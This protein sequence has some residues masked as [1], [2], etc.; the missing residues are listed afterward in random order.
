MNE[1]K[2]ELGYLTLQEMPDGIVIL[3]DVLTPVFANLA[4]R[5]FLQISEEG[6]PPRLPHPE[7][8]SMARRALFEGSDFGST[9]HFDDQERDVAVRVIPLG[10]SDGVAITVRD[11]THEV[12]TQQVRK[13]FVV[14][15]SHELKTPVTG[16]LALGEAI[17]EALP[18]D[19]TAAERLSEQLIRDADRLGKLTQD[20]LDLSRIEDPSSI[21]P[22][23]VDLAELARHEATQLKDLAEGRG[24]EVDLDLEE[25]TVVS[26]DEQQLGLM[27]RNLIDNA[28]RYTEEGGRVRIE[29]RREREAVLAVADNGVGIPLRDQARVFERF[30]RVD[31]GRGRERGGSGLGLSI[32][33]HVAELH[34][35]HV[36]LESELGEGSTFSVR[37][38]LA[39]GFR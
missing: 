16:L 18:A 21:R 29:T 25:R 33:R 22:T 12:R 5:Q 7:L 19:V 11:V 36:S 14:N 17:R 31:E 13:Q 24:V 1:E 4:A 10:D 28:I 3:N 32:V 35:G 8:A 30:Y 9:L 2:G 23:F 37:L 27:V 38:P 39:E 26:G 6:L 15:A 20:L 34:A